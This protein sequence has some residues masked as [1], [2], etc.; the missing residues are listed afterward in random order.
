MKIKNIN[1][2]TDLKNV[3][4]I[5]NDNIDIWVELENDYTYVLTVATPKNLE[6]LMDK[7]QMNYFGPC[8][9][10]IIVKELTKEISEAAVKSYAEKNDGYWLKLY[11]FA[12][13]IDIDVLD[14]LEAEDIQSLKELD[15]LNNS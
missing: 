10:F 1:F 11:H 7:E 15:E 13:D 14:K 8:S 5:E 2:A 9:P 6:Y 4:N 12:N 3:R